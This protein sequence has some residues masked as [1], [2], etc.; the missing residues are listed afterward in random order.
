M[1]YIA[2]IAYS[3]VLVELITNIDKMLFGCYKGTCG[4]NIFFFVV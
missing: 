2:K 1:S 4:E 3:T